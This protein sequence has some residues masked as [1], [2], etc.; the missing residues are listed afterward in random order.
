MTLSNLSYVPNRDIEVLDLIEGTTVFSKNFGKDF[1][2]GLKNIVRGELKGYSDMLEDAK[3]SS[4]DKLKLTASNLNAD[5][6]IN[7]KFSITSMAQGSALAVIASG[8]AV[9]IK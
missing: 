4:L 9:K 7:V 5:A 3:N 8:T 1:L 6:I 2:A